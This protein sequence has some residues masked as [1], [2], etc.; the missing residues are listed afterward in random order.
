MFIGSWEGQ[1]SVL[2]TVGMTQQSPFNLHDHYIASGLL[3]HTSSGAIIL[4]QAGFGKTKVS[5]A[6]RYC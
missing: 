3:S 5:A 4:A 6:S 1:G 2:T